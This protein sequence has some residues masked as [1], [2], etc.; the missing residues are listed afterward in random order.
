[1]PSMGLVY[2][3]ATVLLLVAGGA[4]VLSGHLQPGELASFLLLIGMFF[5][6]IEALGDLYNQ[7]LSA[8]SAAERIFLLLDTPAEVCDRPDAIDAPRFDGDVRFEDVQFSYTP[9]APRPGQWHISGLDFVVPAGSSAAFVGRT[10]AGKSSII[11]LVSRFYDVTGGRVTIDGRDVRDMTMASLHGQMGIV[12]QET[13]LFRGTI[14]DNIKF[15]RPGASDEEAI[16]AARALDCHEVFERL[17]AGYQT[18]VGDRG[19]S[20]SEGE[21][22]LVSFTR[23]MLADPRILVLDEATSAVDVLTEHRIQDALFELA[24]NRTTLIVAH[25]LATVRRADC[26]HVVDDGAIAESGSHDEL[27][28]R[29]GR[30]AQMVREYETAGL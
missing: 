7:S 1:V 16:A 4:R 22:Q 20:L 29:D 25:R 26:I 3:L 10:G 14:L 5:R 18:D 21:R 13:F 15:A 19:A 11:N 2:A 30:Y 9:G 8:A 24:R 17:S 28:A 27:L 6:P 12:L 23:A